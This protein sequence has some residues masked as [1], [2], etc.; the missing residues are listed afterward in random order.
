MGITKFASL[1]IVHKHKSI[2]GELFNCCKTHP[3]FRE[4]RALTVAPLEAGLDG[5]ARG[6]YRVDD[7]QRLL[8]ETR[9]KKLE[10]QTFLGFMYSNIR[11]PRVWGISSVVERPLCMRKVGDSISPFSILFTSVRAFTGTFNTATAMGP[12]STTSRLP[13]RAT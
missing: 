10:N 4:N 7:A 6:I 12:K 5:F 3:Y 9:M 8:S 13:T 1:V 2:L 11:Q